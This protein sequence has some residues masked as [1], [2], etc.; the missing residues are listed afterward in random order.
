MAG[1]VKRNILIILSAALAILTAACS[2]VTY[3]K[4]K[5]NECIKDLCKNEYN[6]NVEVSSVGKTVGIYLPIPVLFDATLNMTEEAQEKIQNVLLSSRRIALSTDAETEFYCIIA[7][8][9]RFPE[10]QLIIIKYFDDVKRASLSYI[11]RGEYF[12]RTIIDMN[13]NPQA[14]K[15][16]AI[17]DVFKKVKVE[18]GWQEK[19]LDDF[20]RSPPATLEDIGYWQGKFYL[21]DITFEEFMAQQMVRRIR[22]RFREEKD[23]KKYIIKSIKGVFE[24]QEELAFFS[25]GMKIENLLFTFDKIGRK[26]ME[27]E[28]FKG[29]FQEVADTIYAYKYEDFD[30][31]KITEENFKT[32]LVVSKEDIYLFK[33]KK[34]V[35]GAILGAMN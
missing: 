24:D 30:F 26:P 32:E 7:Q 29:A 9:V 4:E 17:K 27:E 15:E 14:K 1:Q 35:I 12:K 31:I 16:Q 22:L 3:P 10:V 8:D 19:V 5:L 34:L 25:I 28:I 11:S 2:N 6:I 13:T 33:K 18:D 23:L 21:K 20:F